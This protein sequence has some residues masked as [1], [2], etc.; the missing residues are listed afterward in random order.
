MAELLSGYVTS[1]DTGNDD[2][3]IASR[4]ALTDFCQASQH[5]L[6]LVCRSLVQNLRTFATQDRIA[7][8]TLEIVAFLF[9]VGQFSAAKG[10]DLRQVCLLT[11]KAG[12]KTGNIR[13]VLACAKVYGGIASCSSAGGDGG[14]S[15]E[16]PTPVPALADGVQAGVDEARR[17]LGALM[18]HPWPRVRSVAV[19]EM[20]GVTG[21]CDGEGSAKLT[22]ADWSAAGREQIR[23]VVRALG[24]E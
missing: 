5:N 24:C 20:W 16:A 17:R 22:G 18:S 2:L 12:Y 15:A 4:A 10:V 9:H 3:V 21:F 23:T 19:D 7:V 14:F 13:K 1:A 8:P 6:D 11:Q